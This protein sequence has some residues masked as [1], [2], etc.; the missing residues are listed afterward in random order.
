M[1]K[2][3]FTKKT[4]EMLWIISNIIMDGKEIYYKNREVEI[5]YRN[6]C[7]CVFAVTQIFGVIFRL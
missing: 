3:Y 4:E 2:F 5:I 7:V 1:E 6:V